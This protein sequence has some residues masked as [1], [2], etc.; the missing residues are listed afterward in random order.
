MIDILVITFQIKNDVTVEADTIVTLPGE[1]SKGLQIERNKSQVT[2]P[3]EAGNKI[4]EGS[5][6]TVTTLGQV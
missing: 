4:V 1:Q 5:S 3:V 6:L 2:I